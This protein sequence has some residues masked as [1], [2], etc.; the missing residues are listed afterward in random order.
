MVAHVFVVIHLLLFSCFL[1]RKLRNKS[2]NR[3]KDNNHGLRAVMFALLQYLCDGE[4]F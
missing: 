1:V 2:V 3:Y 4:I